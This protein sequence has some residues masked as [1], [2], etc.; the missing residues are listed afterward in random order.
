MEKIVY[1]IFP[2]K[3]YHLSP[4]IIK[5]IDMCSNHCHHYLLVGR[6]NV[7]IEWDIYRELIKERSL[8]NCLLLESNREL[9]NVKIFNKNSMIILHGD[10]YH[11]MAMFVFKG[12]RNV[13]WVCWGSGTSRNDIKGGSIIYWIKSWILGRLKGVITLTP[14]D[15]LKLRDNFGIRSIT[16]IPYLGSLNYNPDWYLEKRK[17]AEIITV[18]L[19][20]NVNCISTYIEFLEELNIAD[21]NVNLVCMLNYDLIKDSNYYKLLKLGKGLFGENFSLSEDL[22]NLQEYQCFMN[23][24]EVYVCGANWQSG[25]G[26][27]YMAIMLDK[28]LYLNG[29]NYEFLSSLGCKV[30]H[31]DDLIVEGE[32]NLRLM[33][34]KD[35]QDNKAR[36]LEFI[37]PDIV[38]ENWEKYYRNNT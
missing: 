3:A 14:I 10:S 11:R 34:E 4:A 22:M 28:T 27:I 31:F 37:S 29:N 33:P 20:N 30:Y 1:H 16:T 15:N 17:N 35:I 19:G 18:Y 13:H 2:A 9:R 8:K 21:R 24:C 7:R 25:L 36:I 26:A 32:L 5:D 12:Y 38:N 23:D 6:P